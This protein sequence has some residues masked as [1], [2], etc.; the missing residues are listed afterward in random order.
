MMSKDSGDDPQDTF[1]A[2]TAEM[3][4]TSCGQIADVCSPLVVMFAHQLIQ[5]QPNN[6]SLDFLGSL[7][8]EEADREKEA[9]ILQSQSK[10][11][12]ALHPVEQLGQNLCGGLYLN[13]TT[14]TGACKDSHLFQHHN[15]TF[16]LSCQ[17]YN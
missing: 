8:R 16:Q 3:L 9:M 14:H 10:P 1:I 13:T 11:I 7:D 4:R 12:P 6:Q 5:A 17:Q 2:S 15:C